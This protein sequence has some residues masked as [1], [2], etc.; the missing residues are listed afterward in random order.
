[1][2][3]QTELSVAEIAIACGFVSLSHFAKAYR[4][5]FS[6]SPRQDRQAA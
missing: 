1:M 6:V 5:Q 4:R 2:L 3:R